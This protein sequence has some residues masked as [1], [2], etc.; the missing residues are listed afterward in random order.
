MDQDIESDNSHASVASFDTQK[1]DEETIEVDPV[2]TDDN[3]NDNDNNR[4]TQTDGEY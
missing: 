2:F 4:G 1:L 3:D